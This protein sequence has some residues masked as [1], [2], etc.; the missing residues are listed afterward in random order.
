[1][2]APHAGAWIE[3]V[4]QKAGEI[5]EVVAPHAGAWIEIRPK[6]AAYLRKNGRS[7]RGSVD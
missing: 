3:I 6:G 7:P 4:I 1:M 2:V 5:A